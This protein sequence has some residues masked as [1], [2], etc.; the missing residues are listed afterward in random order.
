MCASEPTRGGVRA[1]RAAGVETSH[2]M[3]TNVL[4]VTIAV[5]EKSRAGGKAG[6]WGSAWCASTASTT[7]VEQDVCPP[8]CTTAVGGLRREQGQVWMCVRR[9]FS[10]QSSLLHNPVPSRNAAD[11]WKYHP[12]RLGLSPDKRHGPAPRAAPGQ[13]MT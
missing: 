2:P 7:T 12:I 10:H 13:G 6:Y 8:S 4:L 9:G 1:K 3:D 5:F 11:R